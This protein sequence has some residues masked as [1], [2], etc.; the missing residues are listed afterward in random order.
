MNTV[1]QNTSTLPNSQINLPM[2][3]QH[4]LGFSKEIWEG[5]LG[6]PTSH[7]SIQMWS[8]V[9]GAYDQC[10]HHNHTSLIVTVGIQVIN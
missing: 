3:E 5:E 10:R 9:F 1:T 6:L 8:G 4:A 2:C 7:M